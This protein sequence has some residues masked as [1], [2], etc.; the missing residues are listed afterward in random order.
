MDTTNGALGD[1]EVMLE[2]LWEARV[3]IDRPGGAFKAPRAVTFVFFCKEIAR[4]PSKVLA[5]GTYAF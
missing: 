2:K 1:P 3:A 4:P 5:R